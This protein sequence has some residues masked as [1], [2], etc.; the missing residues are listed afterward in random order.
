MEITI[1]LGKSEQV[2]QMQMLIH[3]R[4]ERLKSSLLQLLIWVL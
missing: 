3:S 2:T 4:K 1:R